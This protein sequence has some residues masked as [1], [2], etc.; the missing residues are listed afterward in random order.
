[1]S[2]NPNPPWIGVDFDGTLATYD[3]YRGDD[4]TGDPVEPMVKLVRKYIHEG[5]DVR[6]FTARKPNPAL[7]RWM[8]KHLGKV[9]PIT[10]TKDSGMIVL[11]DDKAV[12]VKRNTGELFGADNVST[13]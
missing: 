8:Q 12:N 10:H 1:M 9:L 13:R 7:R 5:M 11:Y 2:K 3:H 4:H 6:L